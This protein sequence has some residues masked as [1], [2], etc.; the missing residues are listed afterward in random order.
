MRLSSRPVLSFWRKRWRR[1]EGE[2]DWD[3]G[4]GLKARLGTAR[5]FGVAGGEGRV[6]MLCGELCWR[7]ESGEERV[8]VKGSLWQRVGFWGVVKA[9]LERS[10]F[11]IFGGWRWW[12]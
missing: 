4:I 1:A 3:V 11:A 6:C 10:M 5:N 7:G 9:G 2:V 8:G 12:W